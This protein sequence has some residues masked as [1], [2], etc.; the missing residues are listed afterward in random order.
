MC[1][2]HDEL[3]SLI[4]LV[5]EVHNS[6]CHITG[7][8]SSREGC[9]IHHAYMHD[10]RLALRHARRA[11]YEIEHTDPVL[12]EAPDAAARPAHDPLPGLDPP[13]LDETGSAS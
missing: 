9:F 13:R 5:E 12:P 4:V 10:L 1:R 7:A 6:A 3:K 8:E 2:S 11:V